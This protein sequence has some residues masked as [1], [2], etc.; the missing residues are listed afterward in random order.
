MTNVLAVSSCIMSHATDFQTFTST[1]HHDTYPF[2]SNAT[3]DGRTV[4]ITGASR[5]IG[6]MT[7]LAFARSGADT[8]ILAARSG[9]DSLKTEIASLHPNVKV[10]LLAVDVTSEES[11]DAAVITISQHVS[12]ID[13]LINNAGYLEESNLV[14]DSDR[15]DWWR[16]WEVNIKG[17]YLVTQAVLDL[18]LASRAKT[19]VNI[20][21]KGGLYTRRGA[22]AYGA[23]KAA[24]L[25]F[26]EFLHFEY[27]EQGLL[28]FA[29]HPGSVMTDLSQRLPHTSHG[30]LIDKPELAADTLTWLTE[31][32]R[33]WLG[34]RY[35]SVNWDMAELERLKD[36]I[37][38]NDKLKLRLQ[39]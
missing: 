4:L 23:S 32:T 21:S 10:V 3:Q 33:S 19:I 27:H 30:I 20:S 17:A 18:V 1:I 7:A 31:A 29:I 38:E 24:L 34:G 22:S 36:D 2:I 8:L 37:L 13:V 26:T 28:A 16:T 5:G 25:R 12:S 15:K 39:G 6:R 35:V 14:K 11:V 9:L